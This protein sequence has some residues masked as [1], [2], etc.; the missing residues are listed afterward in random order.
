MAA[1]DGGI[2]TWNEKYRFDAVRPVSAIRFLYRDQT[3]SSW[4][5][6]GGEM[7]TDLPGAEWQSF[8]GT[9]NHSEYP[10]GSACFCAAHGQ[11]R[12]RFLGSDTMGW[13][14]SVAAGSSVIEPRVTPSTDLLLGPWHTFTEIEEDCAMSRSWGGVHFKA[15]LTAGQQLCRPIGDRAFE[16]I[17]RHLRGNGR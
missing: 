15:A 14:V 1:F 11:A 8:L 17:D 4:S 9:A 2:A 16:F 5:G 3:I 7:V 10:S 6:P 12:R 13:S